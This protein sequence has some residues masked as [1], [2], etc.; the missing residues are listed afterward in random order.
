MK[1]N[2]YKTNLRTG[3]N[4]LTQTWNVRTP[5]KRKPSSQLKKVIR[6]DIKLYRA[7]AHEA[8]LAQMTPEELLDRVLRD[9]LGIYA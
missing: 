1:L 3:E 7:L 6:I 2:V 8:E 4:E 9:F 5:L